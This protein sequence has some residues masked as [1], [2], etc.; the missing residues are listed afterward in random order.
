MARRPT[1]N[2][3]EFQ[4]AMASGLRATRSAMDSAFALGFSHSGVKATLSEIRPEMFYKSM[5]S[6]QRPGQWQDVYHVPTIVGLLYVK[7]TNEGL[8]EWK[9]L[10]F[11]KK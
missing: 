1:H 2:L 6:E 5:P 8:Q 3:V 4:A 10:S 9:L 7:F 11:K